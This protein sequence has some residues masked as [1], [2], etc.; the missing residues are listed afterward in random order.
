ML[1]SKEIIEQLKE[2]F[3][4]ISKETILSVAIS[5]HEKQ[6]ELLGFLK[7]LTETS[8]RLKIEMTPEVKSQPFFSVGHNSLFN[9]SY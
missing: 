4:P 7:E 8:P 9:Y 2:V 5:S 3:A 1:L 6:E